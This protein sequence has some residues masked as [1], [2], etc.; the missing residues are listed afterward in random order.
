[1]DGSSPNVTGVL[2]KRRDRTPT[3]AEKMVVGTWGEDPICKPRREV[4]GEARPDPSVS[5]FLSPGLQEDTL[6]LSST[7][8]RYFVLY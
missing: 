7:P 5:D 4:S 3:H 2:M 8:A 1:M 6:L